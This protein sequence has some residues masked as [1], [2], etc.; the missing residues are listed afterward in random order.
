MAFK[1]Q[2]AAGTAR[3][4]KGREMF[5]GFL[6]DGLTSLGRGS[7][8]HYQNR[9]VHSREPGERLGLGKEE[10]AFTI[11]RNGIAKPFEILIEIRFHATQC[12]GERIHLA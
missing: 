8:W 5:C 3:S 9:P 1:H 4:M 10:L 12:A 2:A 11:L 6:R 7:A